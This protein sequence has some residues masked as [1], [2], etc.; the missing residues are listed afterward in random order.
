MPPLLRPLAAPTR[1]LR[2]STPLS[3][4]A[5]SS[6]SIALT[7]LR[8]LSTTA[9]AA[10]QTPSHL[11]VPASELPEYPYGPF[12]WYKQRNQGLYGG[13]KIRTGNTVTGVKKKQ[14]HPK[15]SAATWLPNRHTKRLWSVALQGF[16]RTR[17]TAN[18]LRT[19]DRLGGIDEYL[20]GSKAA[21]IKELGPAGWALRYKIIQ[22]PAIQARFAAERAALGLPPKEV[23]RTTV[24]E[25]EQ[26]EGGAELAP[27]GGVS[28]DAVI[29]EVDEMLE[30]DAEFVLGGEGKEL[31]PQ[32]KKGKKTS[33]KS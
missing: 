26:E 30:N 6:S 33:S 9:P 23:V 28:S 13:A 25:G 2:T 27:A 15:K 8:A 12:R 3:S 22:T 17:V 14:S 7:C 32:G 1:C 24:G 21:R 19:V 20:L 31:R 11:T 4:P 16:V 10:R 29:A 18:V 5:S